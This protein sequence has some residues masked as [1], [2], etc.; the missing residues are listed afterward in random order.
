ML[1]RLTDPSHQGRQDLQVLGLLDVKE[2][3]GAEQEREDGLV[4]KARVRRCGGWA[5]ACV[6]GG[7]LFTPS[8]AITRAAPNPG[9]RRERQRPPGSDS[10]AWRVPRT[11][12]ATETEIRASLLCLTLVVLR[13]L[14]RQIPGDLLG[15]WPCC[16]SSQ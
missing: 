6:W 8:P 13:L 16:F 3:E 14:S 11:R 2:G 15:T 12:A 10:T 4:T 7:T 1:V 5:R 9:V